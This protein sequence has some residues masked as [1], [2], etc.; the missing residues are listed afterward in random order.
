[1]APP[2]VQQLLKREGQLNALGYAIMVLLVGIVVTL[3]V[4]VL[5]ETRLPDVWVLSN[6]IVRTLFIGL[7]LMIILYLVD[8]QRR[9]RGN[10]LEVHQQLEKASTEVREAYDRLSFAQHTASIM[11]SLTEP[12]ALETVLSDSLHH[13][14][15]RVAAVVGDDI[16]LIAE[17][18]MDVRTAESA[19]L[20]VALDVVRA[21]SAI[22]A[23]ED[24]HGGRSI[25]VPLR[26]QG[27]LKSVMCL[28]RDDAEFGSDQLEGLVLMARIIELSLEN[29]MLLAEVRN[30]LDG[31]LAVLSKLIDHRLPE[32]DRRSTRLAENAIAIGR[33]MG[34]NSREL[35]D[36]RIA[37][38][39]AD[40]GLLDTE[41]HPAAIS[42]PDATCGLVNPDHPDLGAKVALSAR[43]SPAVQE[44]IHAHH[45]RLDGSGYPRGLC[46][47]SIPLMARILAVCDEYERTTEDQA[48]R[49]LGN[50]GVPSA[51]LR[52]AGTTYD[53]EVVRALL[54]VL[55]ADD[56][57]TH[58]P[59]VDRAHF[60]TPV[61]LPKEAT[62]AG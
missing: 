10:L 28:W 55:G 43:F 14:G 36:L 5:T 59:F 37:A 4:A 15:A 20:Q 54:Q 33:T 41:T 52:G 39:L 34:L 29:R 47:S 61:A 22:A 25:A 44:A 58:V 51:L 17:E 18:N 23:A 1:M 13:F 11:T 45:E 57:L 26:I 19:V 24:A 12:N 50:G 62:L 40:V 7:L 38:T 16:T 31:T 48:E 32:Y 30:Q 53:A 42:V 60:E 8:Q 27:E 9:L 2:D 35:S 3:I 6:D 21:G 49:L 56:R 46:G